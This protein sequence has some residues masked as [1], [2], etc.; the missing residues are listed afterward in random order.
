MKQF[1]NKH[2]KR[3]YG[4]RIIKPLFLYKK[5]TGYTIPSDK[6]RVIECRMCRLKRALSGEVVTRKGTEFE[7]ERLT[8]KQAIKEYFKK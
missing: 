8:F 5:A 2:T 7:V 4:C 6:N 1:L 3:C